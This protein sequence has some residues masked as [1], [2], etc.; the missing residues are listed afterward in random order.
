MG[1]LV[2]LAALM[3]CRA[4]DPPAGQVAG[5]VKYL[6]DGVEV[7]GKKTV[8]KS[9]TSL[10]DVDPAAE[11]IRAEFEKRIEK[12]AAEI[13]EHLALG[14]WCRENGLGEEATLEFEAAL[15]LAPENP[16]ARKGLGWV[17]SG[18]EWRK[19]A[20]VFEEKRAALK[21]G[22]KQPALDL[23]KWA[24]DNGF[25]DGE[26]RLL[27]A[28]AV[29]D[30]FDKGMI[31]RVRPR[32]DRRRDATVL[33]PPLAGRW[34]ALEDTTGHHQV[35]VFATFAFDFVRIGDDGAS[36]KGNGRALED[37][38]AW[39]E[40]IYACAAGTVTFAEDGFDDNPI[41]TPGAFDKANFVC[42][43]HDDEEY[44]AYGHIQKGSALVEPGERVKAGQ[45]IAR[46][47]NSG[48]SGLPHL[49]FTL[50]LPIFDD[51]GKGGW[52]GIPWR[53]SGFRVLEAAG[54]ACDF[55]VKRARVQEGWV[56]EFAE[57]K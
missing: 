49:H 13:S 33:S 11:E 41:G 25:P 28:A 50:Q 40:T 9:L 12:R 21:P 23:A 16:E 44:T 53:L 14:R 8:W 7:A 5:R 18:K 17:R 24:A 4:E 30:A 39:G 10:H 27:K 54:A 52:V 51:A 6:K 38:F 15:A 43:Q 19:V 57:R 31:A 20:D 47:G 3:P 55:E 35:K 2:C 26:W 37:H 29:A 22:A 32:M 34:K 45:P 46:V 36:W 42:L 56:M 48:A 1:G